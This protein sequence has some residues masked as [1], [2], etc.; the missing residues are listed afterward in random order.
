LAQVY[1]KTGDEGETGLLYGGRVSKTDPRV[2]AYGT[3]DEATAA[4]G[5]ARAMADDQRVKELL[6]RLQRD[7]F[8]V[9]AELATTPD[10]YETFRKNFKPITPEFTTF[11]E[12]CIEDLKPDTPLPR[13]F[14]IPGATGASAALDLARTILR[15][16]ERHTVA[17]KIS[18]LL[19]NQETLRY[20]NRMGDL[21][22][23][24]ARYLDREQPPE[25]VTG[26]R[27]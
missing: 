23:I 3:V 8:T 1:T 17:L 5:L 16:A 9:A 19:A 2:E 6:L 11:L 12:N 7:L 10:Q 18:G 13:A 25:I 27:V 22:F 4:L 21:L 14:I 24:L 20:L 26:G 15:R